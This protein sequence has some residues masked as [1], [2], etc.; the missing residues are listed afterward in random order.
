MTGTTHSQASWCAEST[1]AD[2]LANAGRNGNALTIWHRT[3]HA[4]VIEAA[5]RIPHT[6]LPDG[7]WN[8]TVAELSAQLDAHTQAT[9][10][11]HRADV[12]V[13]CADLVAVAEICHQHLGWQT[14]TFRCHR[15]SDTMCPRFHTDRGQIRMLCTYRGPGTEWAPNEIVDH[16]AWPP[17]EQ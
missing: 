2:V 11:E 8:G 6:H 5:A 4:A 3:P 13:L 1:D 12:S 9:P 17:V 14:Y 7:R 10:T 16:A 15:L